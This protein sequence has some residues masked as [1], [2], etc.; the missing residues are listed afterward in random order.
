MD[1]YGHISQKSCETVNSSN[2]YV[3]T[4]YWTTISLYKGEL[5]M[6]PG[7][8]GPQARQ[9][10]FTA[11][12]T[13]SC[14]RQDWN[15]NLFFAFSLLLWKS[16]MNK[17]CGEKKTQIQTC[18]IYI[19]GQYVAGCRGLNPCCCDRKPYR[20]LKL[21]PLVLLPQTTYVD[22]WDLNPCCCDRKSWV[23]DMS[24]LKW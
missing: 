10:G 22:C 20:F 21:E 24:N 2:L 9:A 18:V 7:V 1:L 16:V 13:R 17:F 19:Y 15:W 6:I 4:T 12:Q 14:N 3:I 5:H 8:T 11:L 23:Y